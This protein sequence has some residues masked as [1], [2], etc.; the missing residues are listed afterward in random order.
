MTEDTNDNQQPE[1]CGSSDSLCSQACQEYDLHPVVAS[2]LSGVVM[3]P[4]DLREECLRKWFAKSGGCDPILI[5]SEF[6]GLANS[7]VANNRD[8]IELW[9]LMSGFAP[10][11]REHDVNLPTILGALRGIDLAARA[12]VANPCVGCAFRLGTLANQSPTTTADAEWAMNTDDRFWCH[13]DFDAEGNPTRR[14]AGYE[15]LMASQS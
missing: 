13:E 2:M 7:V 1:D 3:L 6:V 8:A 5:L 15:K 11:G 10:P 14:C 12:N 4:R 9:S